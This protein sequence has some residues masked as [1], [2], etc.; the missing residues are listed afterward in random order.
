MEENFRCFVAVELS[1]TVKAALTDLTVMIR[2]ANFDGVRIP[3]PD[4]IH[5][6]L[7]FLGNISSDKIDSIATVMS[8][9]TRAHSAFAL[10]VGPA[11]T[12]PNRA[13]ARVIWIGVQGDLNKLSQLQQHVEDAFEALG[14]ARDRR[15]FNPH[16]TVARIGD[17]AS[18]SDRLNV[19]EALFSAA[20]R[21]GLRIDVASVCLMRSVLLPNGAVHENLVTARLAGGPAQ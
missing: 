11:G 18:R 5:L 14:F 19:T 4:S 21:P 3:S 12:F 1:A 6:T 20:P 8:G 17:R 9:V 7:K 10:T 16:L 15:G 2:A 13:S